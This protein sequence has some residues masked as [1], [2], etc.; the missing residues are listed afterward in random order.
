MCLNVETSSPEIINIVKTEVLCRL[1][2]FNFDEL[3]EHTG[4]GFAAHALMHNGSNRIR[5]VDVVDHD[6]GDDG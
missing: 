5:K 6:F 2:F 4:N 3:G 1:S